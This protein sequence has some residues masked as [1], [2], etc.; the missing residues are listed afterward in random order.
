MD[1]RPVTARQ[2]AVAADDARA[3]VI[4]LGTLS[5]EHDG[6]TLHVAGVHR[7]RL[8]AFLAARTGRAVSSEAIIDAL[9]GDDPPPSAAK[10]LQSH[11][12]RLR[13]SLGPLGEQLIVTT[14]N[15]YRLAAADVDAEQFEAL[16]DTGQR[17]LATGDATGA[18]AALEEALALWRGEPFADFSDAEF[19][20]HARTRLS[21]IHAVAVE[22]LAEARLACGSVSAV[23]ADLERL[24]GAEPG[25]EHAWALLM[26]ALYAA[27][28][29]QD[30]LTA[31]QRARRALAEQFGLDP[32]PELRELEGRILAHDPGLAV[33][34]RVELPPALRALS[35]ELVGRAVERA[36][37]AEAWGAAE[38]GSGQ[39]RVLTGP[40]DSGRTRM[41]AALAAAAAGADAHVVYH[42][43]ANDLSEALLGASGAPPAAIAAF[44]AERSRRAPVLLLV[45]DVEW[46]SVATMDA[47]AVLAE[48]V[49]G[50]AALV[51]VA[52]DTSSGGPASGAVRRL[53]P[54]GGRT[55]E[56]GPLD[57]GDIARIVA[58]AGVDEPAAVSAIVS[59]ADG[60]PGVAH[61]EAAAWAE[62][63]AGDRVHR[64]AATSAGALAASDEARD[65]VVDEVARLVRARARKHHLASAAWVGRQPYV[66]LASYGPAE[67]DVFVGRERLVA[68]LAARLLDRRLVVVTGASGSG[69][70]SL[71]RA[72]LVPLVQSGRLP[73]GGPWQVTVTT[74]GPDPLGT[75]D[76]LDRLADGPGAHLLVLDQFEE[77]LVSP[78]SVVDAFVGRLLDLV[79]DPALDARIVLVVRADQYPHLADLRGFADLVEAGLLLVTRPTDAELRRI[80]TEPAE[81]TGA[82]V[83]PGLVDAVVADVGAAEGAL[84]LVSAA[85]AELWDARADGVL[86]LDS[87]QQIGGLAA[88]V[89]RLGERVDAD[90][91]AVRRV[92]LLL[93]DVTDDGS[94][95]R[96]RV[97]RDDVPDDL[98]VALDALVAARLVVD[99]GDDCELV[100]EVVFRAWP[101]FAAWLDAAQADVTLGRELRLGARAWDD[102]GRS[103]DDVWRGARLAASVE[104][105]QRNADASSDQIHAF[106]AAGASV[107][108]RRRLEAEA[109]LASERQATRRLRRSLV[110]ASVLLVGA[111]ILAGVAVVARRQAADERDRAS[112]AADSA[113]AA[114]SSAEQEADAARAAERAAEA[115]RQRADELRVEAQDQADRAEAAE[116]AAEDAQLTAD[117]RRLSAEALIDQR[118]DRALLSAVAG[119]DL[120]ARPETVAGLAATLQRAPLVTRIARLPNSARPQRLA[121]NDAG[122]MLAVPDNGGEGGLV[123]LLDPATLE[124][125]E[126][127]PGGWGNDFLADGRLVT[128]TL[129]LGEVVIVDPARPAEPVRL[130]GAQ[131]GFDSLDADPAGE[132]IVMNHELGLVSWDPS[133]PDSPRVTV[134]DPPRD[135]RAVAVLPGNESVV[136]ASRPE[137]DAL[138]PAAIVELATGREIVSF[139]AGDLLALSGDRTLLATN[140]G[141][142]LRTVRVYAVGATEPE[143]SWT[144]AAEITALAISQ[145]GRLVAVG[146]SDGTDVYTSDGEF[147]VRL[148]GQ[149]ELSKGVA[150]SPDGST[151][152]GT[153][154]D[155]TIVRWDV[156]GAVA[157]FRW[158]WST[159]DLLRSTDRFDIAYVSPRGDVAVPLFDGVRGDIVAVAGVDDGVRLRVETGHVVPR[160]LRVFTLAWTPDAST[161]ATG[162][163]DAK[164]RLF[165][166]TTGARIA[167]W[168]A[169]LLRSVTT[170]RFDTSGDRLVVGLMNDPFPAGTDPGP[171]VFVLDAATLAVVASYDLA[172]LDDAPPFAYPGRLGLDG[173]NLW[174]ACCE[175]GSADAPITMLDTRDGRA[176]WTS[177]RG[178][179]WD[180]AFAPDGTWLAVGWGSGAVEVLR[181]ADG[182][183]IAGPVAAHDGW[184]DNVSISADGSMV[185]TVGTDGLARVWRAD[186][187]SELATFDPGA[188]RTQSNVFGTFSPDGERAL[189]YEDHKLWSLPV[190]VDD[191]VAQVCAAVGRDLTRDEWAA[192]ELNQPYTRAC[193]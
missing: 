13:A 90:A 149:A 144:V 7:R 33:A 69:K 143:R 163:G 110:V 193:S 54:T 9:W 73:G 63:I 108:D 91:E 100:H 97:R 181:V 119:V 111:V 182:T 12:A 151:V 39:L 15:G 167:E 177:T 40:P 66:G 35:D 164:V 188:G 24:V 153:S 132:L 87:Y 173:T 104:W 120:D 178:G 176:R 74:P 148:S 88:A 16:A 37:L 115:S 166:A 32:G 75:L 47:L 5:V 52:A 61:R 131:P 183:T 168:A 26:R 141:P 78:P 139:L 80:V 118:I 185:M 89:E 121:I 59:V 142:D 4:V 23:A 64:A 42:R 84:P 44:V 109:Q 83:E 25:R 38:R 124:V 45:D 103:D 43:G 175:Q 76:Q 2:S 77:A 129:D 8:L 22:N 133:R 105:C 72:G 11:I 106:V 10:T 191:L 101:R 29:Q 93:A 1:G 171:D 128:T 20:V 161:F 18:R 112:S 179:P 140:V 99:H 122:T 138:T 92:L 21:G 82:R 156:S 27:G 55:L 48:V 58:S 53:D 86:T 147:V 46:A 152:F 162:G 170:V 126:A 98:V 51:V 50:L 56:L 85:L 192:F 19:A 114:A 41:F 14:P 30:A 79:L 65:L 135:V 159:H 137:P 94:W 36:W 3:R 160:N 154:L 130:T 71:V 145:D 157:G 189:I 31:F 67:A 180:A 174:Y 62:R 184:T 107:A 81:R 187:L 60:L 57:E 123:H 6:T 34:A 186:D 113:A 117:A 95:I 125:L 127:I 49:E 70:S 158:Q 134:L 17:S 172:E 136:V 169:P 150:F 68:E 96:R 190:V 165:D 155:G 28:R 146:T 102:G 116:V